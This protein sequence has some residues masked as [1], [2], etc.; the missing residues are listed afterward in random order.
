MKTTT[1]I[2]SRPVFHT[3][4]WGKKLFSHAVNAFWK[5]PSQQDKINDIFILADEVP[6]E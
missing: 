3:N 4:S 6:G 2:M 1:G 5:L